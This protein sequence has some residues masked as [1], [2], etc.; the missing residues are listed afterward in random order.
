[1]DWLRRIWCRA[2]CAALCVS[3]GASALAQMDVRL[4]GGGELRSI[5]VG[6]AEFATGGGDVWSAEFA[7]STNICVRAA[8]AAHDAASFERV[9]RDGGETLLWRD[10]PLDG[11]HGVLD[12]RVDIERRSDGSQAWRISFDCRSSDWR[13]FSTDFPR[14]ARVTRDGEGDAMLPWRDHGARLYKKR[15]SRK[16]RRFDYLGYA[17]MVAAFF[18]GDDGLYIA[19]EDPD[20]RIK[21][22]YVEGEQN[23]RFETPVELG[24]EGPRYSVVLSPLKGDWWAAARRYRDFALKQK[25]T[26][27]G[28]IKDIP[29]YPHRICE[30]PLWI[31]IHG[32]PDVVSNTLARAKAIFPDWTTGLHWHLRQHSGHDVNYPEY[33]PEQ[34]GTKECVAFCKSIGQEPMFYTNGRLWT[35]T[36]SGF[37]LAEPYSVMRANGMRHIEKYAPWTPE[38]AVM[39]PSRPEWHKVLLGFTSRM[40]DELGAQSV[41]IDQVGAA[42]G[43]ACYDPA[44]GHPVGG[45][46]WWYDGYSAALAPIRRA[47]NEKGAFVTTEGSGE[48][49]IGM[50]DGYLQVVE[51]TPED[52]P[53][54]NAVYS[55]YTTYFC[56]PENNDD[57]PDAFRALQTRELLWG[58]SLGWFLPDILD[59]PAKCEILRELC[60]FRQANLDALAY[61]NLLDELRF[62][63]PVGTT[64]YE[65][66]G[67]R[68]HFRL[69]DKTFKLPPSKFAE[70][71]DVVGNWWRTS[72]GAIVLLAANLTGRAQT[73][74]YCDHTTG[75]TRSLSL[76][77]YEMR[78]MESPTSPLP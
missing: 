7:A 51:R 72:N 37:L 76:A 61:G 24:A 50:V 39:C 63:G 70:M 64:A 27:K 73:V 29:G 47:W 54:H 23:I 46:S 8:V 21:R 74:E 15:S 69:F 67:R 53:F 59:R 19:A 41:F 13:L 18:I 44:H 26:A 17:P 16:R 60:A 6:S 31:N 62:A 4:D 43:C 40:L 30:I 33:F 35:A 48:A 11:V 36:T 75:A 2:A 58:N 55:G 28:P 25:W 5:C 38:L 1:M 20:A 78:R 22:M 49:Y 12:A 77:P 9:E 32:H 56:S 34:P 10:I 65:W 14:L 52:V 42:E 45:G 68:P 3:A 57:E 71:T 66:L